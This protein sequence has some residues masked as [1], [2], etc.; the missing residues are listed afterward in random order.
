MNCRK[1]PYIKEEY[2][3]RLDNAASNPEDIY[4]GYEDEIE[5]SCWCEKT[6]GKLCWY[7]QCTDADVNEQLRQ[8]VIKHKHRDKRERNLKYKNHLKF[9]AEN[10]PYFPNGVEYVYE[11]Y[12]K[13][14]GYVSLRKPYYKRSYRSHHGGSKKLKSFSNRCVRRYKGEITKGGHYKKIFDYWWTLY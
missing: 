3:D 1:C 14:V 8:E 11:K 5:L 13:D 2:L 10:V 4:D 12:I 9:I 6:G 7:G